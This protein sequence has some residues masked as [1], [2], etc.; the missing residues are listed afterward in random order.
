VAGEVEQSGA[1][2]VGLGIEHGRVRLAHQ[3][4]A[5]RVTPTRKR[6]GAPGVVPPALRGRTNIYPTEMTAAEWDGWE[7][8]DSQMPDPRHVSALIFESRSP[9]WV[10][11]VGTIRH[12]LLADSDAG[13]GPA[14]RG[15]RVCHGRRRLRP[16]VAAGDLGDYRHEILAE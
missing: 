12:A 4:G 11:E 1:T 7:S 3:G 9:T 5:V 2:V 8:G 10:A 16:Q 13:A 6:F 14:I 15:D